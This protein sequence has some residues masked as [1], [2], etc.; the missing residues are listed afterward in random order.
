VVDAADASTAYLVPAA[1]GLTATAVVLLG[2]RW[3]QQTKTLV[4]AG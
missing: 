4:D 1:A 3:L 2:R